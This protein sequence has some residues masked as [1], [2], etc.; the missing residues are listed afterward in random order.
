MLLAAVAEGFVFNAALRERIAQ[1]LADFDVAA[2]ERTGLRLAAV[3]VVV[4]PDERRQACVVIT[5]RVATL[6]R[7]AGQ[8]ALPGGQIE[9]GETPEV[10]ALR[11][12]HEEV[13]IDP[14]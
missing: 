12:I 7:H 9:S 14:G 1:N 10:A 5:R 4:V 6:R 8:W 11:E 3:G 2:S 13:T